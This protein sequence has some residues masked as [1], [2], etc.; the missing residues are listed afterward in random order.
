MYATKIVGA[1][2]L[3]LTLF[4]APLVV[5]YGADTH[6]YSTYSTTATYQS[7]DWEHHGYYGHRRYYRPYYRDH[8]DYGYYRTYP[9]YRGPY[10]YGPG[11]SVNVPFFSFGFGY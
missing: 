3:L 6:T 7:V 8:Y 11:F 2:I 9:Y 1:S 10:Y 4:F 5:A